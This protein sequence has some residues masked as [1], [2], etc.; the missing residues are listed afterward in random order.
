MLIRPDYGQEIVVIGDEYITVSLSLR[1]AWNK[2]QCLTQADDL[3][4]PIRPAP[5]SSRLVLYKDGNS[6]LREPP[7]G[8]QRIGSSLYMSVEPGLSV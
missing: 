7:Q 4:P 8:M 1:N 6:H 3:G 2:E 5:A